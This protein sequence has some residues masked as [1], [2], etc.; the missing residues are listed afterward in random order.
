[1][2]ESPRAELERALGLG[3]ATVAALIAI[4]C[5]SPGGIARSPLVP[6]GA[7]PSAPSPAATS[8]PTPPSA[9]AVPTKPGVRSSLV[10][11]E[12][13]GLALP[14]FYAALAALEQRER[15]LP[16]RVLWLGDSHTAAE[17]LTGALRARLQARFGA[18][19]PGFVRVG[20]KSYRHSQVHWSCDGGWKIEPMPPPRRTVFEDGVFGLG[21]LR[22]VSDD[23]HAQA[24]FELKSGAAHGKLRWQLWYSL[25]PRASFRVRLGGIST[26]VNAAQSLPELP[27]AG[28]STLSLDSEPTAKFELFTLAGKA[29]FYGL[30]VEA[31]ESPGL[32]LDTVGIDGA[33]VATTLA[34]GEKSFETALQLRAPALVAFAFGTNEAFD[35]DRMEKYRSQYQALLARVRLGAPDADCLLVGPPDATAPGG[36]SEP[37][38]AEI[39]SLQRTVAAELGCG[40]LSQLQIMGGPGG[41]D[42][43]LR[44]W[45]QLARGDRLHLTPKGYEVMGNALADH[46]LEAY[47]RR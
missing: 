36:T 38:V 26:L 31:S 45:P 5:G 19:G 14:R 2:I 30:F 40:Y 10:T 34:W 42:N 13:N 11:H 24:A 22:A 25:G 8:A 23:T 46:L 6:R 3:L 28:F 7:V 9:S 12:P 44:Q 33:R 18:G 21:G 27:G 4:T 35:G 20:V 39:D 15:T 41:Y 37:R 1:M 16:V 47:E 29:R 17:Y 43:W 32:V